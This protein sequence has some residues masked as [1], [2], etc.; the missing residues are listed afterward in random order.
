MSLLRSCTPS[1]AEEWGYAKWCFRLGFARR[2]V[3]AEGCTPSGVDVCTPSCFA[4]LPPFRGEYQFYI[5]HFI[6]TFFG[7]SISPFVHLIYHSSFFIP[8]FTFQGFALLFADISPLQD[9]SDSILP[10]VAKIYLHDEILWY[11][12]AHG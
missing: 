1:E 11:A 4:Y 8:H 6:L 10:R 7:Y 3:S 9:N 2:T 5:R 12:R